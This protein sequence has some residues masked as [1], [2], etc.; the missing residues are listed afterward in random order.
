MPDQSINSIIPFNMI[1]DTEMGL[2]KLIEF[3]YTKSDIFNYDVLGKD[4]LTKLYL[5]Q[6]D[7]WNPLSILCDE[8]VS[9]EDMD[10]MYKQFMQREYSKILLYSPNTA[11][12]DMLN[13]VYRN[14]QIKITVVCNT[15]EELDLF[16]KRHCK[17]YR[18]I[19]GSMFNDDLLLENSNLYVKYIKDLF[20]QPKSFEHKSLYIGDYEF[21]KKNIND[22]IFPNIPIEDFWRFEKNEFQYITL[23]RINI[24]RIEFLLGE[25]ISEEDESEE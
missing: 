12:Y 7:N 6:R 13:L 9:Q 1:F 4:D 20:E 21:N 18:T 19:I 5:I 10:D 8:S 11:L 15:E 24:K 14:E 16:N 3:H 17:A 23:N 2:M 25:K 22:S